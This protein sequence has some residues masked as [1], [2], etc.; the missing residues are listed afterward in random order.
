M[1]QRGIVLPH[2]FVRV[3]WRLL[4]ASFIYSNKEASLPHFLVKR[5]FVCYNMNCYSQ[6]RTEPGLQQHL[7][8][9]SACKDYMTEQRCTDAG[10]ET[11]NTTRRQA[12]GVQCTRLNYDMNAEFPLYAP[13][14][15]FSMMQP[16]TL[17]LM[18]HRTLM[19]CTV[20]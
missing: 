8:H 16:T 12:Y 20:N 17:M 7:W 4:D 6:F 19:T 2:F 15:E 9:S 14:K 10:I 11:I 5:M 1:Q 3:L 13:Y 18:T